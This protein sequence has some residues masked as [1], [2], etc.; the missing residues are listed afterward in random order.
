VGSLPERWAEATV[1]PELE[2]AYFNCAPRDQQVDRIRE[3]ERIVLEN[4]H[5]L[6]ARLVTNLP[7][8]RPRAFVARREG[9]QEITLLADTL[10]ID[11]SRA[12]CTVTWRGFVERPPARGV[13]VA[14]LE[15]P[16]HPLPWAELRAAVAVD[17]SAPPPPIAE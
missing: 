8:I 12:I 2:P 13:I 16:E 5:P 7:G 11:T 3:D 17:E 15:G 9:L 14:A 1:P 10:W 4:L 6:H